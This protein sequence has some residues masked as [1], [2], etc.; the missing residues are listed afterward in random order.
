LPMHDTFLEFFNIFWGHH[1]HKFHRV[2]LDKLYNITNCSKNWAKVSLVN[3]V[4][5][6]EFLVFPDSLDLVEF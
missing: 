3:W 4:L 6:N 2:G 5:E 1:T